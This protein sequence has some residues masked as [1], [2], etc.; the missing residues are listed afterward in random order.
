MGRTLPLTSE[1]CTD[2][3]TCRY[4]DVV[5]Y[6]TL[7]VN[8]DTSEVR[9]IEALADLCIVWD[10]EMLFTAQSFES[11]IADTELELIKLFP[12]TVIL[13]DLVS[14]ITCTSHYTDIAELWRR[15]SLFKIACVNV[16]ITTRITGVSEQ[17]GIYNVFKF[18]GHKCTSFPF[19]L[20]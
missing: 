1:L 3:N 17:I 4:I 5:A 14:I 2:D 13:L 8:D 19:S 11:E 20:S 15:S 7:R 12:E 10:L 9:K 18:I 6:N 16:L